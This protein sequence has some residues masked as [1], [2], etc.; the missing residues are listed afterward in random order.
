MINSVMDS[1]VLF[2]CFVSGFGKEINV[3]E[4]WNA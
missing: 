3:M 4:F 1:L 2:V